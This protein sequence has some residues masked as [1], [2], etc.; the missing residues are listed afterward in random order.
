V[1]EVLGL[2]SACQGQWR[3]QKN[4]WHRLKKVPYF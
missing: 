3:A 2:W 1:N 4:R